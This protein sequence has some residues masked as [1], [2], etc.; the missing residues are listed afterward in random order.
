MTTEAQLNA[1]FR[2]AQLK[3]DLELRKFSAFRGHV[4][5]METRIDRIRGELSDLC[6][7]AAPD[8]LADLR[9][10]AAIAGRNADALMRAEAELARMRPN[11]DAARAKAVREFGR[12]QVLS[13][14]KAGA[15]DA[16]RA[17]RDGTP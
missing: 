6:A 12:A 5:A 2:V 13:H 11:F 16:C 3:S 9:A 15:A 14:L 7:S 17:K 1:L 8:S 4:V 10:A